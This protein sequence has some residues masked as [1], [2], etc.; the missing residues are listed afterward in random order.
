MTHFE[1]FLFIWTLYGLGAAYLLIKDLIKHIG[2]FAYQAIPII[3][4][5]ILL[6]PIGFVT[7]YLIY[8]KE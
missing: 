7:A 4:L 1:F 5:Y 3:L 2:Y 6:G 8:T